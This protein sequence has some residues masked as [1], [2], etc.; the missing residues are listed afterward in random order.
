MDDALAARQVRLANNQALYRSVNE[1][2]QAINEAFDAVVGIGGEW[3]CECADAECTGTVSAA[4]YEYEA[5]R[6][7]PRTF[8]VYPGHVYPEAERV[9]DQNERFAIVEKI[10]LAGEVAAK[11]DLRSQRR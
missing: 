10:E 11:T 1:Q 9:V 2:L 6:L 3:I 4:L 7:N 5:I 8:I